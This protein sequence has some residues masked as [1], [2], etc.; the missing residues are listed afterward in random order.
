MGAGPV[1]W[2]DIGDAIVGAGL[3]S[4][5]AGFVAFG[6][7]EL[8]GIARGTPLDRDQLIRVGTFWGL[9]G[10]FCALV[11]FFFRLATRALGWT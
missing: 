9:R 10:G 1:T 8:Y 11:F 3:A 2:G 6:V 5:A 7:A 4:L